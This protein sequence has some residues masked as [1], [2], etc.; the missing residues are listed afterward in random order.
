M[1]GCLRPIIALTSVLRID[2]S[3]DMNYY[4]NVFSVGSIITH[5]VNDSGPHAVSIL[6][7]LQRLCTLEKVFK[8][9]I[10]PGDIEL[11]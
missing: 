2:C 11:T 4:L 7:N 1:L 9:A 10:S 8:I 3:R 6:S 5:H